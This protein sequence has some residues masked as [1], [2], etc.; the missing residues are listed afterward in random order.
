MPVMA[1]FAQGL[2]VVAV[3]EERLVASVWDDVINDSRRI[4]APGAVRVTDQE[5]LAF[6]LPIGVVATFARRGAVRVM[7][8]VPG[9]LCLDLAG[10]ELA[11][12]HEATTGAD[13]GWPG[14]V[15]VL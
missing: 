12:G 5:R 15:S 8:T 1:V 9:A 11:V 6:P 4:P 10:A 14:H 2:P 7:A 3:P 13:M